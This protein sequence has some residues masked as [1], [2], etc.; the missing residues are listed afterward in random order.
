MV[1]E[2]LFF[3]QPHTIFAMVIAAFALSY[4]GL[5]ASSSSQ[6]EENILLGLFCSTVVL[7]VVSSVLLPGGPFKRPHPM[8]WKAVMGISI[9][10]LF[11]LVF[12]LFQTPHDMRQF[13]TIYDASYGVPITETSY[14]MNCDIVDSR[15]NWDLQ[16]VWDSLDRFV[17]GHFVGW[18]I[19]AVMIRD[20]FMLW[21]ISVL[22]ELIEMSFMKLLPNFAE[23]WWDHWI[24]DV[25]ICNGLGIVIGMKLC[26]YLTHK[27]YNFVGF[28]AVPSVQG[29]VKRISEQFLPHSWTHVQWRAFQ[30]RIRFLQCVL[31]VAVTSL[32]EL[33][34]FSLKYLL[35]IPVNSNLNLYRLILWAC[36]GA[37]AYREYF[38]YLTQKDQTKRLGPQLWIC[39]LCVYTEL[40]ISIKLGIASDWMNMDFWFPPI[41]KILWGITLAVIVSVSIYLPSKASTDRKNE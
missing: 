2:V 27:D 34:A 9:A 32:S 13:F 41:V 22:W 23:C 38:Y 28:H 31:L 17:I 8:V 24:L 25:L 7:C 18:A 21:L 16:N 1:G 3:Q 11:F 35:W 37:P 26:D 29:K 12:I 4:G 19:K 14:A 15:G 30:C 20:V 6:R 36:M 39:F 10:Y 33:N 40:L 5:Y